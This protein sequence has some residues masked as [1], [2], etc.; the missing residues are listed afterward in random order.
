MG[1]GGL[2]GS[3]RLSLVGLNDERSHAWLS[4]DQPVRSKCTHDLLRGGVGD[5]EFFHEVDEG[6]DTLAWLILDAGSS[7]T[8]VAGQIVTVVT[9]KVIQGRFQG[10]SA[11]EVIP[12]PQ[13]GL[14]QCLTTG[15]TNAT[16][17][18]TLTIT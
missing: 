10:R 1:Q 2:L 8:A 18:T 14:L 13:P 7:T 6:G 4:V 15:F 16:G 3:G 12:L 11:L 9:G 17:A 5:A